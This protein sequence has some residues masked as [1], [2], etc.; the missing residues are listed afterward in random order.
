MAL[1]CCDSHRLSMRSFF[2]IWRSR[3]PCTRRILLRRLRRHTIRAHLHRFPRPRLQNTSS[4]LPIT[5]TRIHLRG[6]RHTRSPCPEGIMACHHPLLPVITRDSHRLVR[7][8]RP[9][10]TGSNLRRSHNH[11]LHNSSTVTR[12]PRLWCP[13]PLRLALQL[14]PFPVQQ[15]RSVLMRVIR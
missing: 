11:R 4:S 2:S 9:R 5:N 8:L 1:T 7:I 15:T 6:M 10:S 14:L 13:L 3:R 12:A